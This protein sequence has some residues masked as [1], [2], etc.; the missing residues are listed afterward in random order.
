MTDI[1]HRNLKR[2]IDG[3][4]HLSKE[5]PPSRQ[6]RQKSKGAGR[7]LQSLGHFYVSP[8]Q[9]PVR[10]CEDNKSKQQSEEDG[11]EDDICAECADKID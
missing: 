8:C 7:N 1:A 6:G 9:L 5:N 3:S 2:K 11:Y 4:E 10:A